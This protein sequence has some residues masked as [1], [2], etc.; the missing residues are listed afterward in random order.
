MDS[1]LLLYSVRLLF[2]SYL[3]SEASLQYL[4][5]IISC[6]FYIILYSNIFQNCTFFR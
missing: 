1:I 5:R 6:L 2:I 3:R 4:P